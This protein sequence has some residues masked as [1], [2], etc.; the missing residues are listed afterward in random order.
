MQ[1]V[2]GAVNGSGDPAIAAAKRGVCRL[3]PQMQD[4]ELPA[5]V[6]DLLRIRCQRGKL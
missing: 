1:A 2:E 5:T 6:D 3:N 4:I